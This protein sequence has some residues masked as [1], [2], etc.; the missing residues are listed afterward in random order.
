MF[1]V[2][3]MSAF[4]RMRQSAI[5]RGQKLCWKLRRKSWEEALFPLPASACLLLSIHRAPV[6]HD[7]V[8]IGSWACVNPATLTVRV[9]EDH[10][11]V[12]DDNDVHIDS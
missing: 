5:C 3:C 6:T 1:P 2:M 8:H 12:L 9:K 10:D 11:H 4:T 7:Y